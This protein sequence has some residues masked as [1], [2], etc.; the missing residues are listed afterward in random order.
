MRSASPTWTKTNFRTVTENLFNHQQT[1]LLSNNLMI[2]IY[3]FLANKLHTVNLNISVHHNVN[4]YDGPLIDENFLLT[5]IPREL[6]L[7]SFQCVIVDYGNGRLNDLVIYYY[8]TKLKLNIE[9][10]VDLQPY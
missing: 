7:S 9:H 10:E 1:L 5:N 2:N 3:H 4:I 6:T 8:T